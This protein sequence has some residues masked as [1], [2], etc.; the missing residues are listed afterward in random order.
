MAKKIGGMVE[1]LVTYQ[2]VEQKSK[3]TED[4]GGKFLTIREER[5]GPDTERWKA[6]LDHAML[7]FNWRNQCK[8]M[9]SSRDR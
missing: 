8:L 4:K 1:R 2:G 3:C 9:V 6:G 5:K 7:D